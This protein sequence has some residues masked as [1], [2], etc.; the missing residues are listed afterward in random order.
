[1]FPMNRTCN[2]AGLSDISRIKPHSGELYWRNQYIQSNSL[3]GK[4]EVVFEFFLYFREFCFEIRVSLN[5]KSNCNAVNINICC[6]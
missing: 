1:M 6:R 5:T 4:S 3:Q 2:Y